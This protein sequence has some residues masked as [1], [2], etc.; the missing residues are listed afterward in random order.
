VPRI[1][2]DD[3]PKLERPSKGFFGNLDIVFDDLCWDAGKLAR[4]IIDTGDQGWFGSHAPTS[5]NAKEIILWA[6]IWS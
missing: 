4:A 6:Q 5:K 1:E 3:V 2:P